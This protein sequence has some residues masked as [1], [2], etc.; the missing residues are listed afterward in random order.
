MNTVYIKFNSREHQVKGYYELATKATV[1]S[2]P[3]GIYVVPMKALSILDDQHISYRRAT[4]EEVERANAQARNP[5]APVR[6]S[7][8]PEGVIR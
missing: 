1:S 8:K 7:K 4:D 6:Y 2:L 3:D 5:A